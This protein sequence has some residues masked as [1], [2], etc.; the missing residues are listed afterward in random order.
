MD[1]EPTAARDQVDLFVDQWRRE[2]PSLDVAVKSTAIRLRRISH[3]L[4]R[5]LRRELAQLDM[6]IWE[7]EVLLALRHAPGCQLGAG[8]LLRASQVTSGAIT[9]RLTRLEKRGWVSRE[10]D[11]RDRR[12]VL[13]TLTDSGEA[14]AEELVTTKTGAEQR[15][16]SRLDRPTLERMASDLRRLLVSLEGPVDE[17]TDVPAPG[18]SPTEAAELRP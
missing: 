11:P 1:D 3:H 13:V 12:H 15:I 2:Y 17:H 14:R 5:E 16:L 6:E 18:R 10:I 4:D 9:N 8:A 7:F